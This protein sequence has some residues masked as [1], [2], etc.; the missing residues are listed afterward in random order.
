MRN[1]VTSPGTPF[2]LR[3]FCRV[4]GAVTVVLVVWAVLR[5]CGI[6]ILGGAFGLLDVSVSGPPWAAWAI[7]LL[8]F[9]FL[10]GR[11]WQRRAHRLQQAQAD[12][13]RIRAL[14]LF[15]PASSRSRA[16]RAH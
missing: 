11:T 9:G 16:A 15:L 4:S 12:A 8:T 13:Q 6:D 7:L 14:G 2:P 5:V 1:I 10:F 3:T